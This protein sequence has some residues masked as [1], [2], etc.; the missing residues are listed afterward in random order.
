MLKVGH[1][2]AKSDIFDEKCILEQNDIHL[3]VVLIRRCDL[4]L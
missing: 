4:H 2:N 1:V 3:C